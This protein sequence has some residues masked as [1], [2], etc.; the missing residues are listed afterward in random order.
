MGQLRSRASRGACVRSPVFPLL[1]LALFSAVCL[2]PGGGGGS[3]RDVMAVG[4]QKV[5]HLPP[6]SSTEIAPDVLQ[7]A[8]E[9]SG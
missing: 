7:S 3:L 1:V 5:T 4:E 9:A 6:T 2:L 8:E